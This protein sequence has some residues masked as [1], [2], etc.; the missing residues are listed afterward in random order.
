MHDRSEILD[1]FMQ[2]LRQNKLTPKQFFDFLDQ[3]KIGKIDLF[4]LKKG[5][6]ALGQI[7][8]SHA[9]KA[10]KVFDLDANGVIDFQEFSSFFPESLFFFDQTMLA[11]RRNLGM[12]YLPPEQHDIRV[13]L[14]NKAQN[15]QYG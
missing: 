4:E 5:L 1:L 13:E 8:A 14:R 7:D 12:E 2:L 15:T 11:N 3:D 6:S 10:L 9:V